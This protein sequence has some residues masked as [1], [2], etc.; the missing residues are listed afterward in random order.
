MKI[1]W[2]FAALFGI[3]MVVEALP[4]SSEVQKDAIE[5]ELE[6]PELAPPAP[7]EETAFPSRNDLWGSKSQVEK[8]TT[9]IFIFPRKY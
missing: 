8:R 9:N 2:I 5:H 6:L 4:V 3:F 7:E 1:F